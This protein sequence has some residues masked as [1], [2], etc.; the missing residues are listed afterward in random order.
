MCLNR[1]LHLCRQRVVQGNFALSGLVGMDLRSKTIGIVGTGNIGRI[2]AEIFT[3]IGMKL[4]AFDVYKNDRIAEL[5]G[6]Y[7]EMDELY[8]EADVISLHVPLLPSTTGM[9]N[10]ESIAKMKD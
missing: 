3:G 4:L 5:G 10:K 7:V 9:I 6:R 2:A 8:A 1:N